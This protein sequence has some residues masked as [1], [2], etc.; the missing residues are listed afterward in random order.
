[1][2]LPSQFSFHTYVILS[3]VDPALDHTVELRLLDP[4][5]NM[6]LGIKDITIPAANVMDNIH[7]NVVMDNAAFYEEGL[8]KAEIVVDGELVAESNLHIAVKK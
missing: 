6:M 8:Y 4:K 3:D 5:E 2:S 1:M 7:L